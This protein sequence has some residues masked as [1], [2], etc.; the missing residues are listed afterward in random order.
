M[1]TESLSSVTLKCEFVVA[2]DIFAVS[3]E[4]TGGWVV[5][6]QDCLQ[7]RSVQM[8]RTE[9]T[10]QF[11][12]LQGMTKSKAS[13]CSCLFP[14]SPLWCILK[15]EALGFR[16]SYHLTIISNI[17]GQRKARQSLVATATKISK[18]VRPWNKVECELVGGNVQWRHFLLA[19]INSQIL[20]IICSI[21]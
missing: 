1:S 19:L 7:T 16:G 20:T 21:S 5:I 2:V 6:F 3:L 13:R 11:T 17:C 10:V 15:L 8:N 12:C 9:T 4:N 18:I 14:F